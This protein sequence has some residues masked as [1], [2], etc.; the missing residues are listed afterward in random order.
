MLKN[1]N[2]NLQNDSGAIAPPHLSLALH[3]N[4]KEVS[5]KLMVGFILVFLSVSANAGLVSIWVAVGKGTPP[6][7]SYLE[8]EPEYVSIQLT[9]KG[10]SKSAIERH[11][12]IRKLESYVVLRASENS[13]IDV[14]YGEVSLSS[15]EPSGFKSYGR[16]SESNIYLIIKLDD[17]AK[18]YEAT[19]K[20]YKFIQKI[21]LPEDTTLTYG[22]TKLAIANPEKHVVSLISKIGNELKAT[23]EA[24]GVSLKVKVTGLSSPV[25][26]VEI[27]NRKLAAYL[28]YV[29]EYAE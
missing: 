12:L 26:I 10:D 14:V 5:M 24:L 16:G 25:R 28:P 8:I 6:V 11:D 1:P 9:L 3:S 17:D 15:R 21:K 13:E 18:I 19:K 22:A 20:L 23:K 7:Q 29:I 2:K 27:K 4:N